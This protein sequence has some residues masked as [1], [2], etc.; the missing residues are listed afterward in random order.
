MLSGHV[1]RLIQLYEH[2]S[3]LSLLVSWIFREGWVTFYKKINQLFVYK[4]TCSL[5]LHPAS[6]RSPT[7]VRRYKFLDFFVSHILYILIPLFCFVLGIA[8]QQRFSDLYPRQIC[9]CCPHSRAAPRRGHT[10]WGHA[11]CRGSHR[12]SDLFYL[13][14]IHSTLYFIFWQNWR[15]LL[16]SIFCV[17]PC[18]I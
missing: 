14:N 4:I 18:W 12:V 9:F 17:V 13:V 6:S 11:R 3:V 10:R 1:K 7:K 15:S 16:L 5:L 8:H 2:I